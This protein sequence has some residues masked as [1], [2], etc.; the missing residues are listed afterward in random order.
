MTSDERKTTSVN[1]SRM[2]EQLEGEEIPYDVTF[3]VFEEGALIG[4]VKAHKMLLAIV[5]PVFKA[6]FFTRDTLDKTAEE[7]NI[8]CQTNTYSA[9]NC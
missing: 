3:N 5:S 4:S 7:I 8:Y 6:Q 2:L 9:F 1:W